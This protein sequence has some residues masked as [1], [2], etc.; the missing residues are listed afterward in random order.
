METLFS[1][2]QTLRWLTGYGL[3]LVAY[4]VISVFVVRKKVKT[5]TSRQ[6]VSLYLLLKVS[7]LLVSLVV[8]A[9][10]MIVAGI[11]TKVFVLGAVALYVVFLTVDT[12][13]LIYTEKKLKNKHVE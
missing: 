1:D 2:I 9:G 12:L 8:I 10:Y 11:E 5:A 13:F 6:L 4:S 7:K 3:F